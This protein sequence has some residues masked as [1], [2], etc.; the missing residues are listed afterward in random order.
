[1]VKCRKWRKI[2][3][4]LILQTFLEGNARK[5][6]SRGKSNNPG[7]SFVRISLVHN[8][9]KCKEAIDK[10]EKQIKCI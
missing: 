3:K 4:R 10:I 8:I 9:T 6:L 7:E 5:F 2:Y 1:M